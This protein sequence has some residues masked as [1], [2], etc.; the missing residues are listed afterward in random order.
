MNCLRGKDARPEKLGPAPLPGAPPQ[1]E[2]TRG[3]PKRPPLFVAVFGAAAL[4]SVS[5]GA[6][7]GA[8]CDATVDRAALQAVNK[9]PVIGQTSVLGRPFTIDGRIL[10]VEVD[11]FGPQ[12]QVYAVDVT[13]DSM[14]RVLALSTRLE[15][16]SEAPR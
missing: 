4:W 2:G 6:S 14:C 8:A 13:I 9:I 15:S 10:R 16:E 12:S 5:S 1:R 11:V 7:A 3:A